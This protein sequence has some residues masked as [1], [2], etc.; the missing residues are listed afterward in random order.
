[1]NAKYLNELIGKA[2]GMAV[3]KGWWDGGDR[4]REEIAVLIHS[5]IS[6]AAEELRDGHKPDEVYFRADGKPEGFPTEI[7]DVVIRVADYL[8]RME[9]LFTAETDI[10][11]S[12]LRKNSDEV[13]KKHSAGTPVKLLDTMHNAT[14]NF[15]QAE[16]EGELLFCLLGIC[17]LCEITSEKSSFSLP[18]SIEQKMAFNA[19]R[20]ARHGG[21]AF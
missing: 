12:E 3:E 9:I 14:S 8:G 1:M 6:E 4:S 18:A 16:D 19:T 20:P 10:D 11:L 2:H 5:E 17:T 13:I 21:K 15:S 7:A